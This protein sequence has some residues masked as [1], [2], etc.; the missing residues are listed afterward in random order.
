MWK[1]SATIDRLR[2]RAAII[3]ALRHFFDERGVLEVDTPLLSH[4][5]VTDVHLH[6]FLTRFVGPGRPNGQQLYLTTSPEFHMKRLLAAGIG[7]IYQVTKA[8][9][10]EEAGRYH[11]PEFSL[12]EWYRPGF[13]HHALMDEM[14]ELLMYLLNCSSAERMTYR[15]AMLTHA[16]IDPLTATVAEL[17]KAVPADLADFVDHEQDRDVL[18]ELLFSH[19]VEPKIGIQAPAFIYDF[20]ASQAALARISAQDPRVAE[21]FEVYFG[22]MELANGFHELT[23]VEEQRQRFEH[24]NWLRRQKGLSEMPIDELFLASLTHGLPDC[25]GV[26]LGIDR[27]LM[28]CCDTT[29]IE[30]VM[31]FSIDKA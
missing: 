19:C 24:D 11:N 18:L 23:D 5:A 1:P 7:P 21:R 30:Q 29:R 15:Q 2:Q 14:N 25:A 31:S 9:R 8:F 13:D 12:L 26:A 16:A 27:L 10:N 3:K 6:S 17:Q 20:P 28:L 4:A 22:G